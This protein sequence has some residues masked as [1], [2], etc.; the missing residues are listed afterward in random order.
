M[1]RLTFELE[2]R[3]CRSVAERWRDV[4]NCC[5]HIFVIDISVHSY[6][7]SCLLGVVIVL[8]PMTSSFIDQNLVTALTSHVDDQNTIDCLVSVSLV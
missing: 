1:V 3:Y 7:L 6:R 4:R 5:P 2:V 8:M